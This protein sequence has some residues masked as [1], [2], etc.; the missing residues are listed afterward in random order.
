M[1][2]MVEVAAVAWVATKEDKDGVCTILVFRVRWRMEVLRISTSSSLSFGGAG[3]FIRLSRLMGHI[4]F[5][6]HHLSFAFDEV[7]PATPSLIR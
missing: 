1:Y 4:A 3:H 5:D 6:E 2:R 7:G